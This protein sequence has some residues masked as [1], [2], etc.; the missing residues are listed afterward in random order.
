MP[1][2]VYAFDCLCVDGKSLIKRP[3]I[4]RRESLIA[5]LPNVSPGHVALAHSHVLLAPAASSPP[6]AGSD[7]AAPQPP[8]SAAG[9]PP[10]AATTG[11][12][13]GAVAA[14]Q[15]PGG[16]AIAGME[17]DP[18][19]DV[20]RSGQWEVAGGELDQAEG[21][22][23]TTAGPELAYA[24][25]AAA[26]PTEASTEALIR[27]YLQDAL[28]A[29]TEGLMLKAL[30]GPAATYQPSK[31]S[32]SWLKIKRYAREAWARKCCATIITFVCL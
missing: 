27:E 29:G 18:S 13:S 16:A 31:R 21:A 20:Q 28:A 8:A 30:T 11:L 32:N 17:A 5:A 19:P 2:C 12:A 3:L 6:A 1:V 10:L 25:S 22:L 24:G 26:E 23:A 7:A 15:S 14:E 9:K 4:K